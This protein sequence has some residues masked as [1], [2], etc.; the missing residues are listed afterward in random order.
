MGGREADPRRL[1]TSLGHGPPSP[2]RSRL[3]GGHRVLVDG[4]ESWWRDPW[5]GR[6]LASKP[7]FATR[8]PWESVSPGKSWRCVLSSNRVSESRARQHSR[9][10]RPRLQILVVAQLKGCASEGL[11]GHNLGKRGPRGVPCSQAH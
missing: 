10:A 3:I 7:R 11:D 1:Q 5:L 8:V 4:R 6:D 2:A 9:R